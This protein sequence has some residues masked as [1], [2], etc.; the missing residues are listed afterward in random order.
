MALK[1]KFKTREEI[2]AE[3]ISLYT[4][5]DGACSRSPRAMTKARIFGCKFRCGF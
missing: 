5:R 4:E 3:Q 2:P 1:F